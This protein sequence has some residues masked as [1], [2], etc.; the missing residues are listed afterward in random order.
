[1]LESVW[2]TVRR[3]SRHVVLAAITMWVSAGPVAAQINDE[4]VKG[5]NIPMLEKEQ[6][7]LAYL[8]LAAFLLSALA[9]GFKP[10]KRTQQ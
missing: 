9:I 6:P 8:L 3:I 5:P 4:S 2:C 10:S 7:F 1:V